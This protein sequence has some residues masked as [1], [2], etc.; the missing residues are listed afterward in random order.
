MAR[1]FLDSSSLADV[2]GTL[3]ITSR[4][5]EQYKNDMC[6]HSRGLGGKSDIGAVKNIYFVNIVVWEIV[7]GIAC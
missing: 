7:Q 2:H 3:F 6:D 5:W 1:S 4:L